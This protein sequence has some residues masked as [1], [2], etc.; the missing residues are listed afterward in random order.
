MGLCYSKDSGFELIAYSDADLAGCHDDYKRT[1]R[2]IQFLG[3]KL[4][5]CGFERKKHG[6]YNYGHCGSR[7]R[8]FFC[9]L[10]TSH[11]DEDETARLRISLHQDSNEQVKT[12][13]DWN[14]LRLVIG[15][16]SSQVWAITLI[17]VVRGFMILIRVP[18]GLDRDSWGDLILNRETSSFLDRVLCFFRFGSGGVFVRDWI[19][20]LLIDHALSYAPTATAD[21]PDVDRLEITY[22]VDMFCATLKLPLETPKNPFIA[23]ETIKQCSRT[24]GHDQTKINILQIFHVV[25]NCVN[26]D[27]A[28]LLW[29][30]FLHCVQQKKDMI[31]YLH[32]TKLIIADLMEKF[33]SIPKRLEEDYHSI[34]DDI[35][36]VSVYTT[37][38]LI[39]DEFLTDD[40]HATEEYKEYVKVFV[41][42][43]YDED[44]HDLRSVEA[45]FPTIVFNDELSSEKTLSCEPT[46][47][48]LNNNEINFRISFDE[49]DDEDY[50][51]ADGAH[52]CSGIE[53]GVLDLD[54][55]RALQFQLGEARRRMSW[56]QFILALGLHTAKEMETAGFGLYWVESGRQGSDVE[57]MPQARRLDGRWLV[58]VPYL[59]AR[60]LRMFASRR[61]QRAMISRAP[62][63]KRQPDAATGAPETA[64]DAHVADE[65]ASAISAPMQA[66]QPP[67]PAAGPA[68]IMAQRLAMTVVGLS[69]MMSQDGVRY[70]IYADFQISYVRRT[71]R[72]TEDA[73]TSITQHDEQPD[74]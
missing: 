70:T 34:K 60:Y 35:L 68:Q 69:Q 30:D 71:R 6:L 51:D 55:A 73:S 27:Y 9:M 49:S 50:T 25:V 53:E 46:V 54:T 19:C 65:G 64:E 4:V 48:S 40:I 39:P 29:W 47:S 23:L 42:I 36:L 63:P 41:K 17:W 1:S 61:K 72:K 3:D 11:L 16:D 44:V 15:M 57:I 13:L 21:V 45:E 18:W 8:I 62:G 33:D 58:N 14:Y 24:S 22:T 52:G 7:V 67:P 59:L 32:F 26:V 2:G 20:Q 12:S 74:S 37:G 10:C 28:D 43:W 66:C 31:Q 38:M 5:S 56:R